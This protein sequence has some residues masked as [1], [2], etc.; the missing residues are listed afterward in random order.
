MT[1][2]E[3]FTALDRTTLTLRWSIQDGFLRAESADGD[4][5]PITAACGAPPNTTNDWDAAARQRH[6]SFAFAA[7]VVSA[8][9]RETPYDAALRAKLLAV[10]GLP[11]DTP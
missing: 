5:C 3:F 6:L 1:R 11:E 9:D 10:L 4:Y 8:A 7:E 2:E